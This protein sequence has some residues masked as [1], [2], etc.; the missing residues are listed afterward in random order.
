M[1]S[2]LTHEFA[3]ADTLE[4]ARRWLLQIGFQPGQIEVHRSGIPWISVLASE[5]EQYE[6]QMIFEAAELT[7][8]E[9]W[10][11]FWELAKVP[12][13][14]FETTPES[15]TASTI[16]TARPSPV[17]WHPPD[18]SDANEVDYGL[19]KVVDVSMWFS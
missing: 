17:G 13:P 10:P 15:A 18:R 8:P 4:R 2:Y 14:H 7:D 16:V 12:Y 19:T 11:S 5:A 6:V 9:G 1:K 3:H